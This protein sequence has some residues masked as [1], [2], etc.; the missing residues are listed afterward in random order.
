M[1]G[2]YRILIEILLF[3]IGVSI[4]SFI[5]ISFRDVQL[6]LTERSSESQ[7][8]SV[9][10]YV[11]SAI[12]NIRYNSTSKIKIPEKIS[13]SDYVILA[14]CDESKCQLNVTTVSFNGINVTKQLFNMGLDYIITGS[15][16]GASKYIEITYIKGYPK[17]FI[18]IERQR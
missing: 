14:D 17:G 6:F 15:V 11:S 18:N 2:Q 13:E 12:M 5:V 3:A 10:N 7:M 4:T 8:E 1:K 16:A 9:S